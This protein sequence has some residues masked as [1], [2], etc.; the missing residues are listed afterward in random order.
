LS[1]EKEITD[2][3]LPQ[4]DLDNVVAGAGGF[5]QQQR[6]PTIASSDEEGPAL[7]PY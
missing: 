5:Y 2:A 6:T 4:S 1:D 3:L 7:K